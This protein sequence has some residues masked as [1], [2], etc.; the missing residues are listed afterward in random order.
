MNMES[1]DNV[2]LLTFPDIKRLTSLVDCVLAGENERTCSLTAYIAR[3][4]NGEAV[5]DE[6]MFG[7]VCRAGSKDNLWSVV[8]SIRAR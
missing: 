6:Q 4:E 5:P 3:R 2:S 7:E 8:G 1:R